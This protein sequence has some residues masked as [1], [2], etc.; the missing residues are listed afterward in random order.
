MLHREVDSRTTLTLNV[1]IQEDQFFAR[2]GVRIPVP[3]TIKS[4]LVDDWENIT[5]NLHLVPLPHPHPVAN[6]L[7]EYQ[8]VQASK[9]E[10]NESEIDILSEVTQ[11]LREYFD[12]CLG[13]ILL[14]RF[15]RQQY[16]DVLAKTE[17]KEPTLWKKSSN[18]KNKSSKSKGERAN[19][20]DDIYPSGGTPSAV[21][22]IDMTD[23]APSEIYGVEHLCRLLVTMPELISQTNMDTP[24]VN[25]LREE[26]I[27]FT[28][29]LS[30]NAPRLFVKEYEQVPEDYIV[31]IKTGLIITG[32]G[33]D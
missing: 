6:I 17:G 12:K 16:Y 25:R 27:K 26:L 30:K 13:R 2:P 8:R 22:D 15:E 33:R 3:D 20:S 1:S 28:Q 14:Y 9:L 23:M 18:S 4:L 5:K 21:K 24:A 7:E 29:Y 19:D 11:G 10:G 31:A 32:S